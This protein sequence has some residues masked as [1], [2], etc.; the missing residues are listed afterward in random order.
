MIAPK[1]KLANPL[2]TM[3]LSAW[4]LRSFI[5]QGVSNWKKVNTIGLIIIDSISMIYVENMAAVYSPEM[6]NLMMAEPRTLM[7]KNISSKT[8]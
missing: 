2:S 4:N 7:I 5:I 6:P 3:I 8:N 1:T